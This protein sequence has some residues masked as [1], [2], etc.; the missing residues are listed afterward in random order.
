[1]LERVDVYVVDVSSE[2][3]FITDEMLPVAALPDTALAPLH[4]H[5]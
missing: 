2:V 3:V 5:C 1:M 4:A